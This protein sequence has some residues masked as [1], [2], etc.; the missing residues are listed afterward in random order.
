MMR[1]RNV[2]PECPEVLVVARGGARDVLDHR[3]I[4]HVGAALDGA[5]EDLA[6]QGLEDEGLGGRNVDRPLHGVGLPRE[7]AGDRLRHKRSC[8]ALVEVPD[9][10]DP[11]H[12]EER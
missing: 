1:V 12:P 7:T 9:V 3:A 8:C 6:A 2:G 11:S 10:Y 4:D 5:R